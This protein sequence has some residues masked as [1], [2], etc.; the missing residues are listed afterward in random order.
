MKIEA[1]LPPPRVELGKGWG[2]AL[3]IS[4]PMALMTAFMFMGGIKPVEPLHLAATAIAWAFYNAVFFL[5]VKTGETD[6]YRAVLFVTIAV[7]F[8]LVFAIGLIETRGS[9][10]LSAADM[11]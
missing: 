1:N 11:A 5:M 10:V 6:R 3:L 2:K 4:L 8:I 7:C 9:R